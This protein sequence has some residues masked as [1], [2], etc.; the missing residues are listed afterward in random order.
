MEKE[1]W[2]PIQGDHGSEQDAEGKIT[3]NWERPAGR[4]PWAVAARAYEVY[5]KKYGRDQSLERLAA[6]GGFGW[7]ELTWLLEGGPKN[8]TYTWLT[9]AEPNKVNILNEE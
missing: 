8:D 4:V 3:R 7:A 1:Q 5:A 6:R 9:F 2:F